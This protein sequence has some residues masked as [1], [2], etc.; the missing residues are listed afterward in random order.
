GPIAA[1]LEYLRIYG[2]EE[3]YWGFYPAGNL[4]HFPALRTLILGDYS[5][6][7]EKQVEWI[8]SHANTLEEL[9][10]DDAMIGVAVSIAETHVDIPSRTIVYGKDH[11]SDPPGYQPKWRGRTLKS[12]VWKDP[13][14]WHHLFKRFAEGLPKLRHFA[15]NHSHWDSK[16]YEHADALCSAVRIERYGAFVRAYGMTSQVTMLRTLT[17]QTG[18]RMGMKSSNFKWRNQVARKKTGKR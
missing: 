3:A 12:Q 13:T 5:F 9:I 18:E 14:R 17:G 11:S 7:S 4:P 10:L 16:A 15:V 8:L 2:N 1:Q 6:T